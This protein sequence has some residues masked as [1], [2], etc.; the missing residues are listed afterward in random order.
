MAMS[1]SP[2][3]PMCPDWVFSNNSDV[4]IAKD[5]GWFTSYTPFASRLMNGDL[6]VIGIGSVEI[7]V[8]LRSNRTDKRHGTI[9]INEVLHVPTAVCNILGR[10]DFLDTYSISTLDGVKDKMGR[11]AA[12][13]DKEKRLF[14]LKLSG[15]PVGARYHA[16]KPYTATEKAWL[17]QHYK[18]EYHFLQQHSL[19]IYKDEDREEGRA[20]VRSFIA[21]EAEGSAGTEGA[22][23]SN[24]EDDG[25]L[26]DLLSQDDVDDDDANSL[27]L[28]LEED[29]MSHLADYYFTGKQLDW[30]KE[31]Y[32]HSGNF[33]LCYGLKAFDE[34]DC[35]E[36]KAILEAIMDDED[37]GDSDDANSF[38]DELEDDPMSHLADYNFTEKQLGWIK[39]HYGHSGNF[40]L[41]HGLKPFDDNDCREGRAILEVMMEDD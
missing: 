32:K 10:G 33:L 12:C 17:K 21:A 19:S 18:D 14:C 38:L 24:T 39:K 22:L 34:E 15:R 20:I 26:P 35:R 4:S 31:H 5:R 7:P 3:S 13:F 8:R 2:H 36:G 1:M 40:L 41:N 28:E 9:R 25:S 29:P 23:D 37:D 27:L 30:I 16:N 6:A 11:T